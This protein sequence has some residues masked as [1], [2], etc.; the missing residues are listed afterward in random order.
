MSWCHELLTKRFIEEGAH[1]VEGFKA[2]E[3]SFNYQH[4]GEKLHSSFMR[5]MC[6]TVSCTLRKAKAS[7]T[8]ETGRPL[9]DPSLPSSLGRTGTNISATSDLL[10]APKEC[11]EKVERKFLPATIN[12]ESQQAGQPGKSPKD[13]TEKH[14]KARGSKPASGLAEDEQTHPSHNVF[15]F[16]PYLHFE[17]NKERREMQDAIRRAGLQPNQGTRKP[18]TFT[19][20]ARDLT[21]RT[22]DD[23]DEL[24]IRAHLNK[25][26]PSSSTL[27][28]RRTLD[29]FFYRTIDTDM[30][31]DDQVIYKYEK[32]K[33]ERNRQTGI[34]HHSDDLKVIMVDQLWMWIMGN[35]LIVTSFPQRWRQP[36]V[37]PMNVL[38]SIIQELHLSTGDDVESVYDLA[39]FIAGRCFGTFDRDGSR[40][41]D[42][43]E[44]SIG[45]AMDDETHLFE[46]FKHAARN[47]SQ[48]LAR[49]FGLPEPPEHEKAVEED[50][51]R[52]ELR[53]GVN[54]ED[55]PN[56]ADRDGAPT[57]AIQ[58]LLHIGMEAKL[59]SEVKDIRDELDMLKMVFQQQKHVL[60]QAND[61]VD[62]I[63]GSK[64]DE[65]SNAL[66]CKLHKRFNQYARAMDHS[67][68]E[69]ERMDKQAERIYSSIRDLLD[70]KQKHANAFEAQYARVQAT[71]TARQGL[72]IMVFTIV[73]VIF[74]PLSFIAAF[75]GINIEE[76]PHRNGTEKMSLSFVCTYVFGIGLPI[77]LIS[78]I[79]AL[80]IR[81]IAPAW[82][83]TWTSMFPSNP[84]KSQAVPAKTGTSL[85]WNSAAARKVDEEAF[86]VQSRPSWR[87]AAGTPSGTPIQHEI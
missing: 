42:M 83:A 17:T 6:Q 1:D 20:D 75:L 26:E 71:E 49:K 34:R 11:R 47:V 46:R 72:T 8:T 76:F 68:E 60:P 84:R 19:R 38:E 27:H 14:Q 41:L 21:E 3:R 58:T 59:L 61:A 36:R 81:R 5:P 57:Q 32:K 51:H 28:L 10:S 80:S 45:E 12:D 79:A 74:L 39:I 22:C 50:S 67:I 15:M 29:Q 70:L 23:G 24:L 62:I 2:L 9:S 16:A 53:S 54:Y 25:L 7:E 77:G 31:D 44:S 86:G 87:S 18:V 40:F 78:V 65:E 37:D 30:R 56:G 82:K 73:T 66:K 33:R 64:E 85:I 35:D 55:Q 69:I 13:A 63:I 4:R 52:P 43:F 48:F